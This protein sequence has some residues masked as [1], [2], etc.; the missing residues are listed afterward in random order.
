[1]KLI[2]LGPDQDPGSTKNHW[3]PK[4]S[5]AGQLVGEGSMVGVG[6]W[7]VVG[8]REGNGL[9]WWWGGEWVSRTGRY[10]VY[11]AKD[12]LHFKI[13][14]NLRL[15]HVAS[16][17]FASFPAKLRLR[18]SRHQNALAS[19]ALRRENIRVC[20]AL[21]PS[22]L[23]ASPAPSSDHCLFATAFVKLN[24]HLDSVEFDV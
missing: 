19:D 2:H 20:P 16:F 18:S 4:I 14:E 1:M 21:L 3:K 13:R 5:L 17:A 6:R 24:C 7:L 8:V 22:I 11:F 10:F 9:W 12:L 15:W 23:I